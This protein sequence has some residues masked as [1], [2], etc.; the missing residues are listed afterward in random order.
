MA[1]QIPGSEPLSTCGMKWIDGYA[2]VNHNPRRCTSL[3]VMVF[4]RQCIANTPDACSTDPCHGGG[5]CTDNGGGT[6]TCTCD[7]GYGGDTC[8]LAPKCTDAEPCENGGTCKADNTDQHI[9]FCVP[10]FGG[11]LC[12][13]APKCTDAKPCENS[14]T[15]KAD[16]TGQ[17]ICFCV[18][19]FGGDLCADASDAST[20][21]RHFLLLTVVAVLAQLNLN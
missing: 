1:L 18:P 5:T 17:H 14:G 19:G 10:G 15:C 4:N 9:C 16:T 12:A 21:S 13:D 8:E 6:A 20:I 3:I 11:D 2:D 7:T